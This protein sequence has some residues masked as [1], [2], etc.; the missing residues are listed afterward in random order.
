MMSCKVAETLDA[1]RHEQI[2][3][4]PLPRVETP[5]LDRLAGTTCEMPNIV[6]SKTASPAQS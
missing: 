1:L 5:R 6:T 4:T 3:G 2:A